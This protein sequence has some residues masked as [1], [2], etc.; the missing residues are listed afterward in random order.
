MKKRLIWTLILFAVLSAAAS[1][2]Q[3]APA[4]PRGCITVVNQGPY[5]LE[6][7]VHQVPGQPRNVPFRIQPESVLTIGCQ[8]YVE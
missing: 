1:A 8:T 3:F 4:P 5:T 6:L 2:R 7:R